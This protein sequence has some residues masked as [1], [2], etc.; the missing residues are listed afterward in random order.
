LPVPPFRRFGD[1]YDVKVAG[2]QRIFL[3]LLFFE[4][5]LLHVYV[6]GS[7]RKSTVFVQLG[8]FFP[9]PYLFTYPP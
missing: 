3:G 2:R 7:F 9:L 8:N 1:C 6:G 5:I 4:K